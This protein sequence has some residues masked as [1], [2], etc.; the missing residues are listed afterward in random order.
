MGV[1][2]TVLWACGWCGRVSGVGVDV[3]W[4]CG[5]C[6]R[7][8]SVG[9]GRGD[10]GPTGGWTAH[11]SQHHNLLTSDLQRGTRG[12]NGTHISRCGP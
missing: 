5:R 6:G 9:V 7:V 4:A 11:P 10:G 3:V 12:V 2:Q 1:L 8:C